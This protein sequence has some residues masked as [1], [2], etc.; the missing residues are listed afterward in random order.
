M[1]EAL[2]K[3]QE[4]LK[5]DIEDSEKN[6]EGENCAD[7]GMEIGILLTRNQATIL[8]EIVNR[9]LGVKDDDKLLNQS[10]LLDWIRQ[11]TDL[12]EKGKERTLKA[13]LQEFIFE[14][15]TDKFR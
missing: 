8:L 1:E 15:M 9:S 11:W 7:W 3:I 10:V 2:K 6:N 12:Y 14:Y 5:E 13:I 4:S